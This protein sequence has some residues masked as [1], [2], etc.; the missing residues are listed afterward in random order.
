MTRKQFYNSPQWKVKRKEIRIRDRMICQH[1][2]K[3][4]KG[5]Y[6]ELKDG[7]KFLRYGIVDHII[8]LT[9]DNVCDYDIALNNNNL[10]L[11]CLNCHN[12]K[13]FSQGFIINGE[14]QFNRR[15]EIEIP[16]VEV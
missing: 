3:P 1:C 15:N 6:M 10:Q 4:I 16:D 13:T 12:T 14:F 5:V 9:D 2:K 8:E 7:R 11:L